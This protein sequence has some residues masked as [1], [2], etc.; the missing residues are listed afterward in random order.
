V[1]SLARSL[2][3]TFVVVTHELPSIYAIADRVIML[4]KSKKGIIAEGSPQELRDHCDDPV[5]RQF[6]SRQPDNSDKA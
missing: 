4:D 6:F 2:K 5:V 1:L 3:I